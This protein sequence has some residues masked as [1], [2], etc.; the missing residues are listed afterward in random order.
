MID[1]ANTDRPALVATV[2][3][4]PRAPRGDSLRRLASWRDLYRRG[5]PEQER[6]A[7]LGSS[8]QHEVTEGK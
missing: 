5:A 6:L 3:A 1:D 4:Q 7:A 2:E 8:D